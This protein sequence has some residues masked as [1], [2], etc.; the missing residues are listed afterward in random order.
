MSGTDACTKPGWRQDTYVCADRSAGGSHT[1]GTDCDEE[2]TAAALGYGAVRYFD[3]RRNP[4]TNYK[5][6]YDQMLDTR[7]NTAV[8]LL[9][10]H[11]RLESIQ[12]KAA[13]A[14]AS[15]ASLQGV[16]QH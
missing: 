4:T 2:D 12:T 3:L 14:S 16:L 7:G 13:A 9:Y 10:T 15:S 5:F 8:Y 11:A 1:E 6:S